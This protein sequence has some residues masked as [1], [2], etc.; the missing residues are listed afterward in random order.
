MMD[1]P[2]VT[3]AFVATGVKVM[4]L[5]DCLMAACAPSIRG[6]MFSCP[7]VAMKPAT[8]PELTSCRA[9]CPRAKP[10]SYSP[11]PT[12]AN[13]L[14]PGSPTAPSALYETTGMP[15]SSALSTGERKALLS[16]TAKAI[17]SALDEIALLVAF[18]ISATIEF[19]EPV[20]WKLQPSRLN[21]SAAPYCV[22]VKNG[23]VVTWQTKTNFHFGVEGKL[24][25]APPDAA[26]AE[27]PSLSSE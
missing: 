22:G 27:P 12:Y 3:S 10:D 6:W 8:S 9:R 11:W 7:G 17:P 15:A 1:A 2:L 26:A 20:H 4:D 13:R 25:N 14:V 19:C 23:F 16:T 18:T 5:P 24:P 21:A